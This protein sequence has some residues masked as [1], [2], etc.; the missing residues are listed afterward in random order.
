MG[1]ET[2]SSPM[3]RGE[4]VGGRKEWLVGMLMVREQVQGRVL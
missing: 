2:V 3:V 1:V 4:E